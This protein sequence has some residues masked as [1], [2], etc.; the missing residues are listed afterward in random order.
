MDVSRGVQGDSVADG[1]SF[2]CDP[3]LPQQIPSV[4][5]FKTMI[6]DGAFWFWTVPTIMTSPESSTVTSTPYAYPLNAP[7]PVFYEETD[8]AVSSIR[9]PRA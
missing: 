9:V 5:Y 6:S 8:S 4:E 2:C 1:R 7:C 3:A